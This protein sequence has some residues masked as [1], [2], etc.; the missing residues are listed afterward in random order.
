MHRR[1][2]SPQIRTDQQHPE[3]VSDLRLEHSEIKS[4]KLELDPVKQIDSLG[5]AEKSVSAADGGKRPLKPGF[6]PGPFDVICARGKA[7]K[8]HQG[9][10]RFND[11][12]RQN[13]RKYSEA[14]SKIEKTLVVSAIIDSVRD[15]SPEGGFVREENGQ[16]FEIGDKVAREKVG[17]RY[18]LNGFFQNLFC[19]Q[20]CL[21]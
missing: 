4:D 2:T 8:S 3:P 9:N 15:A 6:K 10:I 19:K 16:W 7:V 13:L 5:K 21:I 11:V 18:V 20:I 1:A 14:K 12:L 17:Q